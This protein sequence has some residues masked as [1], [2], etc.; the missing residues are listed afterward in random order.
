[1]V[2]GT[3]V[4]WE[5]LKFAFRIN[6]DSNQTKCRLEPMNE[7]SELK[8]GQRPLIYRELFIGINAFKLNLKFLNE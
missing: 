3:D 1:L 2:L 5:K 7:I 8:N 6:I 4:G